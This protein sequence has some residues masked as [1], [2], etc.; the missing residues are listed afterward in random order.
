MSTSNTATGR[1]RDI[2]R[3]AIAGELL[4][5][6]DHGYDNARGA[7]NLTVDQRPS[8]IVLAQSSADVVRAVRLAHLRGM[9]VAPQGTGHGSVP[10]DRLEGALLL[11]TSQMRRV[12]VDPVSRSVRAEAGAQWQDV[13]VP[14]ASHGLAALAGT[15]PNVGVTGYTLGGGIGWLARRYGLAANSLTAAEIVTPDGR[16]ARVDAD[17]EP[18]LFWAVKGGGG[19]VGVVTALEM[20][21]YPVRALYA[22]ALFFP[23][24]RSS[25]VL[26][27]WRAWTDG[28]PDELTSVG[29]LLRLPSVP[30]VPEPLRGRAF[31]IV[32]AAYIGEALA[33][34]A[35]IAP[36]RQLGP[37]LDTFATI[38][39]PELQK[40][41]MD[42]EQPVPSEGDGALL[43]DAPARAIDTI[44]GLAGPDADT[45]LQSVELRHLGGALARDDPWGGAQARI[46]ARYAMFAGGITP[47]PELGAAVRSHAQ[48]MK[49]ALT[50]WRSGYDYF[51]FAETP[52]DADAVLPRA[53]YE[54]LRQIKAMYDPDQ[55][56][57]S[58]HPV[59]PAPVLG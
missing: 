8:A 2:M 23:I 43:A 27:A 47:T 42:P 13:T 10:L 11:K 38:P 53:A 16:L 12:T 18:D 4:F 54:R 22:G 34:A 45:V 25:E 50:P 31:V 26:H 21:L 44:V 6:G 49:D 35:L 46:G 39:P 30:G 52:A 7:W 5:P 32:E 56:I 14:A 33:G 37:E 59:R 40:L 15:S 36:L 20:R 48:A 29:R 57:M 3:S 58:A 51:N 41:H 19:G 17:H 28:L 1:A 55:A 9:R 24:G